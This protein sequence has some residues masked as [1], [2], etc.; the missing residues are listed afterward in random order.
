M[1]DV[2]MFLT[3]LMESRVPKI[4]CHGLIVFSYAL[5]VHFRTQENLQAPP[6]SAE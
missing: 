6:K 4:V 3:F 2:V 5:K 1:S